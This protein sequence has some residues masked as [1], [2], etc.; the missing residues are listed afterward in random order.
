MS[1]RSLAK[2]TSDQTIRNSR[3][4]P[5]TCSIL[6]TSLPLLCMSN[7]CIFLNLPFSVF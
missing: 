6:F 7:P 5:R 4:V 1:E 2:L 3:A